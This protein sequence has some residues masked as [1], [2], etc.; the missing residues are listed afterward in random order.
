VW[1]WATSLTFSFNRLVQGHASR[2]TGHVAALVPRCRMR[3]HTAFVAM[4]LNPWCRV[5]T[6]DS[7]YYSK[8]SEMRTALTEQFNYPG[9]NDLSI[10]D[11]EEV[12]ESCLLSV[13]NHEQLVGSVKY[14]LYP[15]SEIE[16]QSKWSK[17]NTI[18]FKDGGTF[19]SNNELTEH[20]PALL[21]LFSSFVQYERKKRT[22]WVKDPTVYDALPAMIINIAQHSRIN[23][24]YWLIARCV[25]HGHDPKMQSLFCNSADI[26][27]LNDGSI[28]MLIKM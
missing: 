11:V 15:T 12:Y 17:I 21:K 8:I 24:G 22:S 18:H 9:A 20:V 16:I 19:V 13:V 3:N 4:P 6:V 1:G 10:T 14:P 25:R 23:S 5:E 7:D 27:K 2:A 28:G 26:I